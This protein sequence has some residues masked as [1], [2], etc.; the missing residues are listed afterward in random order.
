MP[1]LEGDAQFVG[2]NFLDQGP[3]ALRCAQQAGRFDQRPGDL[4]SH[5][6]VIAVVIAMGSADMAGFNHRHVRA[7]IGFQ[8]TR[9]THAVAASPE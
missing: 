1:L 7:G 4:R 6:A 5:V 2:Y 9:E 3:D 8:L